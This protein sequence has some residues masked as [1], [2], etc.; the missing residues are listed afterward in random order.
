MT[1]ALTRMSWELHAA[2]RD[3]AAGSFM[4]PIGRETSD[5]RRRREQAAKAVCARC[6]VVAEC[7]EYALRVNEPI[8]IWGGLNEAERRELAF[9]SGGQRLT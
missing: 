7:L 3:S 9:P 8:G 4:P 2:C 5:E 6:P 1:A